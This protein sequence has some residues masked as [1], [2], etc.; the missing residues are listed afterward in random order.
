MM[1]LNFIKF[2]STSNSKLL[3]YINGI[4]SL[5]TP[6]FILNVKLKKI[7]ARFENYN[8]EE[9]LSRVN[10]YNKLENS[11]VCDEMKPLSE[12]KYRSNGSAYFVDAYEFTRYFP[13]S[14]KVAFRFGDVTDVKE[15]PAITKSRAKRKQR[16]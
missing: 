5:L 3:F 16:Q 7:L 10:Y 11:H 2:H 1:L 6:K 15:Y 8:A 13:D 14:L 4:I 12:F 9:I